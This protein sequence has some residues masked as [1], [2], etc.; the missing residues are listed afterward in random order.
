[1]PRLLLCELRFT[2]AQMNL[3]EGRDD[4]AGVGVV[5]DLE[6]NPIGVLQ[7][8]DRL[9]G[10]PQLEIESAEVV[11]ELANIRLV[12]QLLVLRLGALRVRAGEHPVPGALS[13]ER[14]L[15]IV[16]GDRAPVVQSLGEL[17]RALDVLPRGFPVALASIAAGAPAESVGAEPVGREPGALG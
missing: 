4:V 11:Q 6:E 2:R 1:M 3:R 15:E 10:L 9:V 16:V 8:L 7:V 5:A 14:S 12:G 13:D 17:E